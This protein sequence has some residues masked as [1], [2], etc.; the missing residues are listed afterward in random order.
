MRFLH[1]I[2]SVVQLH[3]ALKAYVGKCAD[4]QFEQ[5]RPFPSLY[6]PITLSDQNDDQSSDLATRPN[7]PGQ[8]ERS[9]IWNLQTMRE[10]VRVPP[11]LFS[12]ARLNSISGRSPV[13]AE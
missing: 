3:G 7:S 10:W 1:P 4:R 12:Y 11:L 6:L 13:M 9:G 8:S 5:D 2:V